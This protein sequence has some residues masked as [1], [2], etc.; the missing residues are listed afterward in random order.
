MT[1][2]GNIKLYQT[3]AGAAH[4][5]AELFFER[6]TTAFAAAGIDQKVAVNPHGGRQRRLEQ[7]GVSTSAHSYSP[8]ATPLTKW[9][10]ARDI[11]QRNSNVILSWM[12]RATAMTPSIGVPHVARLG[13]FYNLKYYQKCDWLVANTL[14]IADYLVAEGWPKDRVHCQ[15]NFVPDGIN[16]PLFAGPAQ[17]KMTDGPVIVALGRLH[18]NKAFDCLIRAFSTLNF[19]QLWLAGDGPEKDYLHTL[20]DDLGV[21]DRVHFLGWQSDP[22]SVIRAADI[23]VCP[24]RHEPFGNVIA[25]AMACGKPIVATATNGARQLIQDGSNGLLVPIDDDTALANAISSL[26]NQSSLAQALA[27]SGRE[28]WQKTLS[29]TKITNE[30][31]DFLTKVA[32]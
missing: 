32:G 2:S 20:S 9:R 29:P 31:I 11:R 17:K 12:N 4:G 5:G 26:E 16:G 7:N 19:G 3:M 15:I 10:L 28:T 27:K 25:E 8:L 14:D 23:F 24:S 18:E 1:A 6:L 13:G 22:Q 21:A 30:W